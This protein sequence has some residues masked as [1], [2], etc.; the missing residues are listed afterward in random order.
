MRAHIRRRVT[1]LLSVLVLLSCAVALGATCVACVSGHP[2]IQ[3]TVA[4]VP[5]VSPPPVVFAWSLALVLALTP[6]LIV[7]SRHFAP[8]RASPALLQRFLF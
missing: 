1:V 2:P 7:R 3:Q 6:L 5:Q 4:S 8:G